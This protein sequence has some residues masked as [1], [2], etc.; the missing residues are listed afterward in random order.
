META[1]KSTTP[2]DFKNISKSVEGTHFVNEDI[3]AL[4]YGR[5][6]APEEVSEFE[7]KF[8]KNHRKVKISEWTFSF[9]KISGMSVVVLTEV[10]VAAVVE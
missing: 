8:K 10:S 3:Q 5:E 9:V 1:S 7:K 2:I 6:M 4:K